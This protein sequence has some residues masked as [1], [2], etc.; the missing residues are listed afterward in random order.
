M[1]TNREKKGY[2]NFDFFITSKA[3]FDPVLKF[4]LSNCSKNTTYTS[5]VIQNEL[6]NLVGLEVKSSILDAPRSAIWFSVMA[7]ECV[8]VATIELM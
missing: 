8:D 3:K 2:G 1:G 5:S 4:Q 6:N 7:D